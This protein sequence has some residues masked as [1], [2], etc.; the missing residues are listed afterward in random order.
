MKQSAAA[1]GITLPESWKVKEEQECFEYMPEN[2]PAIE[3]F[4]DIQTQWIP[5]PEGPIGLNHAIAL[6]YMQPLADGTVLRPVD[7]IGK[8]MEGL[9]IIEMEILNR[10]VKK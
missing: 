8:T 1:W 9:R 2:L 7:S 4:L 10:Q 6:Q 3:L 5:G